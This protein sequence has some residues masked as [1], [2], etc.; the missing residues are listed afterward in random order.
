MI[1]RARNDKK[2]IAKESIIDQTYC[3]ENLPCPLFAKE[4][5]FLPFVKGGKQGFGF[6]C[7]YNYGI[8]SSFST[9]LS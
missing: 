8:L 7:L 5:E 4:G 6:R 9:T 2:N 1:N 3:S